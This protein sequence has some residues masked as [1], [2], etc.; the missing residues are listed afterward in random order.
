MNVKVYNSDIV[1]EQSSLYDQFGTSGS[2]FY[3]CF[4]SK[5]NK[6]IDFIIILSLFE[7]FFIVLFLQ[8]PY[9]S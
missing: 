4:S 6:E 9:I 2:L 5:T 3:S 7:Y 8:V 1:D